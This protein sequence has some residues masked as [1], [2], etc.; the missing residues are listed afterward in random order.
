MT[1]LTLILALSLAAPVQLAPPLEVVQGVANFAEPG[2]G[3]DYLAM[4][5][6]RGTRVRIT[7][8][9]GSWTTRTTDYGPA[10]RTGD[11]ADIALVRFADICGW[12]VAVARQRGECYVSVTILSDV[13]LPA[14][15]TIEE[16]YQWRQHR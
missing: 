5:L 14:T 7:G 8:A 4:R 11:I 15:D 16:A 10:K 1:L 2:H 13:E 12:S 9:G 6:D 3:S